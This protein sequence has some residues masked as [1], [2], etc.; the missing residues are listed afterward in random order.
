L[1]WGLGADMKSTKEDRRVWY[2]PWLFILLAVIFISTH[3]ASCG[4]K[5]EP[6]KIG[7]VGPL[8]GR[9]SDLG[10]A[11]RD[12]VVLAIEELNRSGGINGRRVVLFTRDDRHDPQEAL[13]ADKELIRE[14]VAAIIGHMTS[15]M[16]IAAYSLINR[17]KVL[18]I[19]PTVS[20]NK[21]TGIDDYFI[22]VTP[23]NRSETEH[24]VRFAY[25][26][27]GLRKMSVVYDVSNRAYSKGYFKNFSAEFEKSGGKIALAV[28]FKSGPDV[29]FDDLVHTLLQ[30]KPD[31]LLIVAG[32]LDTAMICQHIRM[33]GSKA[34]L[35]SSGWAMTDDLLRHGG[36]AVEGILFSHLINTGST[37]PS[38]L[39][40]KADFRR[41]FGREP[42]FGAINAYD[43]AQVL[44]KALKKNGSSADSLKSN[45]LKQKI[46]HGLQGDLHIDKYGDPQRK[47][48]LITVKKGHFESME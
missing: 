11:G 43:A 6:I 40:F 19:S 8:T 46:F 14:G 32:A 9:L 10:T 4:N 34:P 17:E 20:T 23:P 38:Y 7:F 41:R 27:M 37:R 1:P 26:R 35:I 28:P 22:R 48:F 24:L 31:G 25:D 45:I 5:N 44:F 18:M 13:K 2:F 29:H 15:A 16:S 47:R 12:G 21:L 39:K 33:A 3:L 30:A 42:D 36:H